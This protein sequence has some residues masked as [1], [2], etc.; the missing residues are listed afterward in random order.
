MNRIS[1]FTIKVTGGQYRGG[2]ADPETHILNAGTIEPPVRVSKPF[3]SLLASAV[4]LTVLSV[5]SICIAGYAPGFA[6]Y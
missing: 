1:V 3:I 5:S 2:G 6:I 4:E